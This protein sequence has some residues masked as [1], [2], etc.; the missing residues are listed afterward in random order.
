MA[1]GAKMKDPRAKAAVIPGVHRR[2]LLAALGAL[3]F[4]C[5]SS[6]SKPE[7]SPPPTTSVPVAPKHGPLAPEAKEATEPG[8]PESERPAPDVFERGRALEFE[9][10]SA[11]LNTV[12]QKFTRP[13]LERKR[14]TATGVSELK[15]LWLAVDHHAPRQARS[16][17]FTILE[18][19]NE[20]IELSPGSHYL[21]AFEWA[22][23]VVQRLQLAAFFVDV[24][25]TT[26]P[27]SP[28]CLLAT[29]KLTKNGADAASPLR[30]L[31]IPLV[32]AIDEV[33]Y[34]ASTPSFKTRGIA[35]V[36]TEMSL[37]DFPAGD[38]N[39]SVRCLA[40]GEEVGKDDQVVTLNPE[41]VLPEDQN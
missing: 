18:L 34:S 20:D 4:V 7:G 26:L 40:G 19:L 10:G 27:L 28:G 6:C 13:E 14:L 36:G 37:K 8:P 5:A 1:C 23:G 25:P 31:A 15:N 33:E 38:I 2:F 11:L 16:S 21:V 35:P 24:A 41:A 12:P 39:L 29:P 30:L 22:D 3:M 9:M 32:A 17:Q